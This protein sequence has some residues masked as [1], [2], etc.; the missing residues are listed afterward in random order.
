MNF[1]EMKAK[2]AVNEPYDLN[3]MLRIIVEIQCSL[4]EVSVYL[5]EIDLDDYNDYDDE[6]DD[7]YPIDRKELHIMSVKC[8]HWGL[9]TFASKLLVEIQEEK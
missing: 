4:G 6:G 3:E 9:N 7:G 1:G 5:N 2:V 8:A